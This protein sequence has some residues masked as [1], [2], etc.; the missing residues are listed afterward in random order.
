M[1]QIDVSLF[2]HVTEASIHEETRFRRAQMR[3]NGTIPRPKW[4]PVH[5]LPPVLLPY[6]SLGHTFE[7][8]SFILVKY[9]VATLAMLLH[10]LEIVR[11]HNNNVFSLPLVIIVILPLLKHEA[12]LR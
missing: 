10:P 2:V 4:Y 1:S 6:F 5:D 8:P 3:G 9:A 12:V 7:N 11:A